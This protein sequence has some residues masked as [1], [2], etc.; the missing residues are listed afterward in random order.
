MGAVAT[1]VTDGSVLVCGI[2]A[3]TVRF[4]SLSTLPSF[5]LS[6]HALAC[7]LLLFFFWFEVLEL[8]FC[9]VDMVNLLTWH[10]N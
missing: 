6:A 5:L 8:L 3:T 2:E 10:G 7:H 9:G 4:Q 1:L